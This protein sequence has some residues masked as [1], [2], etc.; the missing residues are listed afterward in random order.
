M[1]NVA[2]ARRRRGVRVPDVAVRDAGGSQGQKLSN[3]EPALDEPERLAAQPDEVF[4]GTG[5]SDWV[6]LVEEDEVALAA[7]MSGAAAMEPRTVA[8]ARRREDWPRWEAAIHEELETLDGMGTWELVD[9]PEGANVVGSKWVFR[10][11]RD[12]AG[13]IA[14]Y[15][16]RLVAQGF[17]QVPGVDYF[18]TFAPVA[19]LASIRVV[20][21]MSAQYDL[22]LHQVDV[23]G[24]YLNGQLT[25]DEVIYMRQPP[26]YAVPGME[27]KVC[28]LLKTLYGLKQS[29][30]R[31]YQRLVEILVDAM[32]FSR[33]EVDQAV[34]YKHSADGLQ[35]VVVHVDDCTLS[36][37]SMALVEQFKAELR[38][39]VEITDLGELHWLLGVEV[40]RDRENGTLGLSQGSYIDQILARYNL[41]EV[42]PVSIPMDPSVKLSSAQAPRTAAE[43]TVMRDKPY[44]EAVGSLMYAML[45]TRPDIAFAVNVLSRFGQNPGIAHWEALVRVFK[46]LKGTRNLWL[47]FGGVEGELQGFAD[48]DGSMAED[49]R[50]VTGYAF[51][52]NGGAVS[53]SSKRQSIVSLSTTESEYVAATEAAKEALWIR[54]LIGQ[55]FAPLDGATT[56]FSDNQSAIAL[57]Q[58]HQYHART[59]HIDIRFHFIRWVIEEGRIRLVYCPTDDMV[60]DT[61][62]KALPSL[63]VKHFARSLGLRAA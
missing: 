58:D 29:G 50:A 39:H 42:K 33:S 21:A 56:L 12:A 5:E 36:A 61:L 59:K 45:A 11:K 63:K 38:K 16:A 17:S 53:W 46:Y 9:A 24:A 18:D 35:I 7:V 37:S 10:A 52:L 40:R 27:S 28:R 2:G 49:R 1:D 6:V 55:V 19:K 41:E 3:S 8:E 43:H 34:F 22:E 60:A 31:W 14:R 54:S 26:G 4:E 48:A 15:K 13:N 20:L 62:T 51:I 47:T 25:D 57:A 30:R 32:G 44:L 23:K